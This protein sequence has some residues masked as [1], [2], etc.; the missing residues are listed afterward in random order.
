MLMVGPIQKRKIHANFPSDVKK[1][2]RKTRKSEPGLPSD[3]VDGK[4]TDS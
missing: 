2:R 1:E 4:P 3:D